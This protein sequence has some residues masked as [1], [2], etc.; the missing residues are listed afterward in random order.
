MALFGPYLFLE[1]QQRE[2]SLANA[3]ATV[4]KEPDWEEVRHAMRMLR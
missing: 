3:L 2:R 4:P 1:H